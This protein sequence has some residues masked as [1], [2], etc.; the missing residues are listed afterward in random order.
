MVVER[1]AEVFFFQGLKN[2]LQVR[3]WIKL[4]DEH[5]AWAWVGML[6]LVP[7]IEEPVAG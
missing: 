2:R 4:L 7:V 6:R 1:I 3:S 5:V